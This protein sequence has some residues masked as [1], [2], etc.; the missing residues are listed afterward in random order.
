MSKSVLVI[1]TPESCI[2]CKLACYDSGRDDYFCSLTEEFIYHYKENRSPD[3]PLSPLPL[4][5]SIKQYLE[6]FK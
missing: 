1:D 4:P 6:E 5:I 3:C 2:K